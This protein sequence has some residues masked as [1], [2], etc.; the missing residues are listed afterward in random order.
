MNC[1]AEFLFATYATRGESLWSRCRQLRWA[2][3]GALCFRRQTV[4]RV[5]A[6]ECDPIWGHLKRR[7]LEG[8]AR[9]IPPETWLNTKV[10]VVVA[11]TPQRLLGDFIPRAIVD[12]L[13]IRLLLL[14][15]PLRAQ[16]PEALMEALSSISRT[17]KGGP[18][19]LMIWLERMHICHVLAGC[20]DSGPPDVQAAGRVEC[21]RIGWWR[22]MRDVYRIE[23]CVGLGS[24]VVV[25]IKFLNLTVLQ[26]A[27]SIDCFRNPSE[28]VVELPHGCFVSTQGEGSFPMKGW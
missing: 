23:I 16:A 22:S 28:V 5:W 18:W 8:R 1:L 26:H 4:H 9:R 11:G 10:K 24:A 25:K 3:Q 27:S 21:E 15:V 19:N 13:W 12:I 2:A 7:W 6:D 14:L 20:P 17:L